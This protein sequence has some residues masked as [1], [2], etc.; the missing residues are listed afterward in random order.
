MKVVCLF[1]VCC[2][3]V[4]SKKGKEKK[5]AGLFRISGKPIIYLFFQSHVLHMKH[6][7]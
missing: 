5:S 4:F 6:H 1:F 3:D 7:I 2:P